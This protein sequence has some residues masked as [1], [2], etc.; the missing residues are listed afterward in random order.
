MPANPPAEKVMAV[1]EAAGI[2]SASLKYYAGK[3]SGQMRVNT[4]KH[5]KGLEF[6]QVLLQHVPAKLLRRGSGD[7]VRRRA[8]AT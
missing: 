8:E 2:P 3:S 7:R 1:F 5:A 6:K 4:I